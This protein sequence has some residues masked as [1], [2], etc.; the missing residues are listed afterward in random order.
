[1]G[2]NKELVE[3]YSN[4]F[5]CSWFIN[6]Y[7]HGVVGYDFMDHNAKAFLEISRYLA[8]SEVTG[9][10]RTTMTMSEEN[11]RQTVYSKFYGKRGII[12][13]IKNK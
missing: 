8:S 12:N 11:I 3:D 9:F 5:I 7:L 2:I 10:L 1:M 13:S 4:C 6:I